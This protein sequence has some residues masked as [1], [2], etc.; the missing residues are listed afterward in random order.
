MAQTSPISITKGG[1]TMPRT[2]T[3]EIKHDDSVSTIFFCNECKGPRPCIL[4][5]DTDGGRHTPNE[6]VKCGKPFYNWRV[7]E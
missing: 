1:L 4:S 6:V 7:L 2:G 5:F 3:E